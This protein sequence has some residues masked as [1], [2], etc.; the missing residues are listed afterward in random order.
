ML[1]DRALEVAPEFTPHE[2]AYMIWALGKRGQMTAETLQVFGGLA[3]RILEGFKAG[4]FAPVEL[5]HIAW[6]MARS[7]ARLPRLFSLLGVES[8]TCTAD[9]S[10]L[11]FARLVW[12]LSV[13]G[14]MS[15]TTMS[16]LASEAASREGQL[17]PK[18]VS[19]LA[20]SFA[21]AGHRGPSPLT[22]ALAA[23]TQ[24]VLRKCSPRQISNIASAFTKMQ[25]RSPALFEGLAAAATRRLSRCSPTD[26]S[27]LAW[28]FASAGFY[29][30][31]FFTAL[32]G[33]ALNQLMH[34]GPQGLAN[35]S[36]SFAELGIPAPR[37]QQAISRTVAETMDTFSTQALANVVVALAV[38]GHLEASFLQAA[39]AV[40]QY[41]SINGLDCT[42]LYL[43]RLSLGGSGRSV[44]FAPALDSAVRR[45]WTHSLPGG[46][47]GMPP[48]IKS[49]VMHVLHTMHVIFR[50]DVLTH[51][52]ELV[53]D[54]MAK[55]SN[56]PNIGLH[57]HGRHHYTENAPH[58]MRGRAALLERLL[59]ARV[60]RLATIS[61]FEWRSLPGLEE[62]QAFL[63]N[64]LD[65]AI[66]PTASCWQD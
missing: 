45:H 62:Q 33:K 14:S 27:S 20:W 5:S 52:G 13:S 64:K 38:S 3:T 26:V 18:H 9:L 12:A 35:L 30:P 28:A 66:G 60:P 29:A 50:A 15:P 49:E 44:S 11:H 22:T 43:A 58:R 55:C 46:G 6:S 54:I 17:N 32:E 24:R 47:K 19:M 10:A 37:L 53:V 4:Q 39:G 25:H 7:G 8:V 16:K 31:A 1:R 59:A 65:S 34:L 48:M 63:R 23:E 57:L 2:L 40:L 41:R 36:W 56:Q 51:D 61:W 21:N 42:D